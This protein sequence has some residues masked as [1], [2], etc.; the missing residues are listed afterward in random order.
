MTA[1][2]KTLLV[3]IA[4]WSIVLLDAMVLPARAAGAQRAAPP[5]ATVPTWETISAPI[6]DRIS[7]SLRSRAE[8]ERIEALL[9]L[10][11]VAGEAAHAAILAA[12]RDVEP[13]RSVAIQVLAARAHGDRHASAALHHSAQFDP[14]VTIRKLAQDAL[15]PK[16][17]ASR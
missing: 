1:L 12:L 13:V 15:E 4:L 7:R 2:A 8:Q 16:W 9:A 11:P 6:P 17:C 3:G 14:S 5:G 10:E